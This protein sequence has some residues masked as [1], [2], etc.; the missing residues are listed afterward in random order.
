MLSLTFCCYSPQSMVK[1][2]VLL[3]ICVAAVTLALSAPTLGQE[4][5]EVRLPTRE[6]H[7]LFSDLVRDGFHLIY[8]VKDNLHKWKFY[9]DETVQPH[10]S[11]FR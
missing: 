8:M 11:G 10:P 4:E 2:S 6:R 5:V 1:K 9:K 3:Q 7:S